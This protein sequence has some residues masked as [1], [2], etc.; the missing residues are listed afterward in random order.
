MVD[1]ITDEYSNEP[2]N[3]DG[4]SILDSNRVDDTGAEASDGGNPHHGAS[5]PSP[6]VLG[7]E[8]VVGAPEGAPAASSTQVTTPSK[9]LDDNL[10]TLKEKGLVS[11]GQNNIDDTSD[12]EEDEYYTDTENQES[13]VADGT[14]LK[15]SPET[16]SPD[17]ITALPS[18][19]TNASSP[20]PDPKF[21]STPKKNKH[22]SESDNAN[23]SKST[24]SVP[25][26]LWTI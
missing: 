24:P 10:Q 23:T 6:P 18:V 14:V 19:L 22:E 7:T 20:N 5:A 12:D 3:E 15:G 26:S 17:G 8:L 16:I 4:T 9:H 2:R 21:E 1:K 25:K 11:E 13:E